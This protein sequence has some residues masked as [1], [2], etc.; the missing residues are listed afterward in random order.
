MIDLSLQNKASKREL[1]YFARARKD[2]AANKAVY[3][4]LLPVLAFYLIFAYA[5]MYGA[6]IAFKD[7]SPI[8]GILGSEW[9]GLANFKAFFESPYFFRVLRNTVVISVSTLLVGFPAPILLALLMNEIRQVRFKKVVQTISYVPHFISLVVVAGMIKSFTSDVGFINVFFTS[10][11]I[12][13][14]ESMLT[15]PEYFL[16]IYVI[17]DVWQN[18]GWNTIIYLAALSTIS[19]DL[20]EAAK[21][22]G[23]GKLRQLVSITLPSLAPTIVMLLVLNIGG[24]MSL[25]YEKIILLYNELTYETADVIASFV[26]RK[27]LLEADYSFSTAV[28][29]FNSVINFI[30]VVTANGISRK[31]SEASIW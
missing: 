29:L 7:Y 27:G 6:I 21:I 9:V 10:L 18:V 20:Y 3:L 15:V 24:L 5:P 22:D 13:S 14:G 28:G 23:A 17:S 30:L 19:M 16:P 26:Y 1:G 25:G 8:K 12:T 31:F 4:M 2:L 11:G